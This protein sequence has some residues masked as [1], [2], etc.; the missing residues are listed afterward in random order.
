MIEGKLDLYVKIITDKFGENVMKESYLNEPNSHMP[1]LTIDKEKWHDVAVVLHDDI[2]MKFNYLMNLS[3]IDYEEYMEVIYHLFSFSRDE[4]VAVKVQTVRDG[5]SV[6]S[7]MD[8][9]PG[10]D[11]QER[12]VYDL[13]GIDF[14]GREIT[15]ILLPENWVGYPLRK[16]YQP[17]DKEV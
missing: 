6:P 10:A 9:W 1:I 16:D 8:I 12:E 11:W 5:G 15:R 13:L 7:V 14:T 4:Y 17:Y 2:N 3:G